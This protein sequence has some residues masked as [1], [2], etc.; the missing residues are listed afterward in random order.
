MECP[1]GIPGGSAGLVSTVDDYLAFGKMMLDGGT[2]GSTR[3]CP[4]R[5]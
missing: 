2:R 1:A 4:R 3:S 5:R